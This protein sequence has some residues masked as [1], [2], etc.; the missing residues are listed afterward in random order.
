MNF[1]AHIY[2]S[3]DNKLVTIGNFVADGVRGNKYKLYPAEIQAGIKLHREI[4][5]FT[6]A[7]PVFRDP[8]RCIRR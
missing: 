4:D 2:L 8:S 7:H 1:L 6:D 3:G 5:T